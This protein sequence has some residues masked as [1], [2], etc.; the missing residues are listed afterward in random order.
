MKKIA[1]T[2][3]AFVIGYIGWGGIQ[4]KLQDRAVWYEVSD[5]VE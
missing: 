5:P 3:L 2:A 1:V 4:K